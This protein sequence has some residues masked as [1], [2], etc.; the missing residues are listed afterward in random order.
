VLLA[1][2]LCS[3]VVDGEPRNQREK[4][5]T[6]FSHAQTHTHTHTDHS[7]TLWWSHDHWAWIV[8][9]ILLLLSIQS[10]HILLSKY[11]YLI[12]R[13]CIGNF[14]KN[15]CRSNSESRILPYCFMACMRSSTKEII[16][17]FSGTQLVASPWQHSHA[18]S[19]LCPEAS[20][21]KLN[22]WSFTAAR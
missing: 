6:K 19:A 20:H 10:C 5:F 2:H 17:P 16:R 21:N 13:K 15:I 18:H 11:G 3:E 14:F 9:W 22:L 12:S 1:Q 4:L 7:L 8:D